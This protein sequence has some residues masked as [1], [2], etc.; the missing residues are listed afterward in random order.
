MNSTIPLIFTVVLLCY[1][2]LWPTTSSATPSTIAPHQGTYSYRETVGDSSF[3]FFWEMQKQES[4]TRISVFE[5]DKSFVNILSADGATSSW[6][7][8]ISKAHEINVE[9]RGDTLL[10][11]HVEAGEVVQKTYDI[12]HRPWYQPLSYSLRSF[13][14][15][16]AQKTSFWTVRADNREVIALT[17]EKKGIEDI[18]IDKTT[19]TAQKVEVR[20]EGM[21][22]S[23]WHG[24]YHYRLAD[25][26]F[27][28]YRSV[29]G[30]PGTSETVVQL[31]QEP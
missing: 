30:L 25:H 4:Q 22:A 9:R 5:K 1:S 17:A 19:Y 31:V 20:A 11:T 18:V 13:L 8:I 2:L 6:T 28:Q 16:E 15:S 14:R 7:Y 26:L 29:H 27:L 10:L 23:F 24:T 3:L 21:W 12:D